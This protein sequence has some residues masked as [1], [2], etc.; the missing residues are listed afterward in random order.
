MPSTLGLSLAGGPMLLSV[1][2]CSIAILFF[3]YDEGQRARSSFAEKR[4]HG[5]GHLTLQ[6]NLF[7]TPSLV[8]RTIHMVSAPKDKQAHWRLGGVTG[9]VCTA[10]TTRIGA[11]AIEA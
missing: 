9:Q 10:P 5:S 11:S 2:A 1:F 7:H 3:L 4:R 8:E 6:E